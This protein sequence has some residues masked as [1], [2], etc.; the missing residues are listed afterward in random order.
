M[1]KSVNLISKIVCYLI[2]A[3]GAVLGIIVIA[4]SKDAA[5]GANMYVA[6]IAFGLCLLVTLIMPLF[7][8]TYTKK[9]LKTFGLLVLIVGVLFLICYFIPDA[10]LSQDFLDNLKV[11]QSVSHWVGIGCYFAYFT[12]AGALLAIIYSAVSGLI[13]NKQ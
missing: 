2:M 13:K 3:V 1:L 6:Y 5:I 7:F 12:F 9:M 11:S 4:S 10:Q 8:M